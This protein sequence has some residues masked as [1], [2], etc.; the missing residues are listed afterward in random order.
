MQRFSR[1]R[2]YTMLR[3]SVVHRHAHPAEAVRQRRARVRPASKAKTARCGTNER[4]NS[5]TTRMKIESLRVRL[6]RFVVA[7]HQLVLDR[8]Q[9]V[10][11]SLLRRLV[12]AV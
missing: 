1:Q 10:A 6:R 4:R 5:E 9:L 2:S 11:T 7:R 8:L 3:L 12:L